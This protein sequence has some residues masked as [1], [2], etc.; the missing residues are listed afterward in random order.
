MTTMK[1]LS[2]LR[3]RTQK[4]L[5][6]S[7][8][9]SDSG[10]KLYT[11]DGL[12]NYPAL[13]TRDFSYMVENAGELLPLEDI[14]QGIEYLMAGVRQ[15]GWVP[16][17][18]YKDG[19]IFYTAGASDFPASPNLDNGC[20][21]CFLA[22]N[23]LAKLPDKEAT[24]QFLRWKDSLCRGVD[25]LPTAECGLICNR[26][27]PPHS[28]YGFTDTVCKTGLLCMETLLF[29]NAKR[30]LVTW[31]RK[32]AISTEKY[33]R[34]VTAIEQSFLDAFLRSDG[35]LRAATECCAQTD[36]WAMCYAISINFPLPDSIKI[37]IADWLI[38]HYDNI[39]QAG[40][41]RHLPLNE[42]WEKTFVHVP[43]GSYQNGAFWATPIKWLCDALRLRDVD[44]ATKTLEDMIDYME[45]NGCYECVNGEDRKLDT[46]VA[47]A[48][49]LY[50][51][52]KQEL[53]II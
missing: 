51:A 45:T 32:C 20:F 4:L 23:Y 33:E 18:I 10:V 21:L 2:N 38:A 22:D 1:T 12:A 24:A 52:L 13:W 3:E 31:M 5:K 27:D 53:G 43:N 42:Y 17:R 41:L 49:A 36:I 50:G 40:Q 47:S 25:C 19:S 11:P 30:K 26:A 16:D 46:Y 6:G 39:V 7:I 9:V 15:D 34:D 48:A 28:P 37:G 44:L 35:T 14:R 29:W 8:I